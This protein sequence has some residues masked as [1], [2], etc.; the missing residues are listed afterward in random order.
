MLTTL[1]ATVALAGDPTNCDPARPQAGDGFCLTEDEYV[2]LGQL[3]ARV[4]DLE[5]QVAS[6]DAELAAYQAWQTQHDG[7]LRSAIE[8]CDERVAGAAKRTPLE[9]HGFSLGLVVGVA[10]TVGTTALVLQTYGSILG[11]T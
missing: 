3:R 10:A 5:S 6:R 9:R 4:A 1:L 11:G 8:G 2:R 7:D